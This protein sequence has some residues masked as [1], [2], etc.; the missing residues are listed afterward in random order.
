[1]AGIGLHFGYVL[2]IALRI[3]V[4]LTSEQ[5]RAKAFSAFGTAKLPTAGGAWEEKQPGQIT[6]N[7]Q[8]DIMLIYHC[9]LIYPPQ[10]RSRTSSV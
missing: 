5:I 10:P 3:D 4:F 9:N 1:M 7:D 8:R 6:E 2:N